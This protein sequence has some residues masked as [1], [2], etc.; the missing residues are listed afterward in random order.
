MNKDLDT[1]SR[2]DTASVVDKK[3]NQN[4]INMSMSISANNF[5]KQN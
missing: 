4:N 5:M 1:R 3:E 2:L